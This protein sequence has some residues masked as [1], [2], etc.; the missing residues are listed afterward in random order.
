[1]DWNPTGAEPVFLQLADALRLQ[2]LRGEYAAGAQIPPVRVLAA[3]VAVNP[4]T[5][6]R[7]LGVLE[8]EGLVYTQGTQGR[9]VTQDAA[10]LSVAAERVKRKTV[11]RFLE[12]AEAI[13]LDATRI[14]AIIKE[15]TKDE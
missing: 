4:N 14:I 7:A 5:V 3:T 10:R 2:I 6:Q 9:F 13:G 8:E 1:M 12:R 15:E 11:K